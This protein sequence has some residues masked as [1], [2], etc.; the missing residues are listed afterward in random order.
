MNFKRIL[1]VVFV[2]VWAAVP[3]S[4]QNN[5]GKT[6]LNTLDAAIS[7][8]T[9]THVLPKQAPVYH[10]VFGYMGALSVP[11][12][13]AVT[14]SKGMQPIT[15]FGKTPKSDFYDAHLVQIA[16]VKQ[17]VTSFAEAGEFVRFEWLLPSQITQTFYL[18]RLGHPQAQPLPG[19]YYSFLRERAQEVYNRGTSFSLQYAKRSD[20]REL[21]NLQFLKRLLDPNITPASY[22]QLYKNTPVYP[23]HIT[24]NKLGFPVQTADAGYADVLD[25]YLM[26]SNPNAMGL[27]NNIDWWKE[28]N[29]GYTPFVLTKEEHAWA[30]KLLELRRQG[31]MLPKNPTLRDLLELAYNR[32]ETHSI[33]YTKIDEV[34]REYKSYPNYKNTQLYQTIKG[35]LKNQIPLESYHQGYYTLENVDMTHLIVLDAVMGG[36]DQQDLIEVRRALSAFDKLCADIHPKDEQAIAHIAILQ[37]NLRVVFN[38]LLSLNDLKIDWLTQKDPQWRKAELAGYAALVLQRPVRD[39]VGRNWKERY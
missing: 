18:W 20:I 21:P 5:K 39:L 11:S 13:K 2:A 1:L 33:P 31:E 28:T 14:V 36:V 12:S 22:A 27:F 24:L 32:L 9:V 29:H 3:V 15:A 37:K 35:M 23:K 26:L 17:V 19:D 30:D 34:G 25:N 10:P 8:Q 4:A 38:E 7:R 6:L 16:P